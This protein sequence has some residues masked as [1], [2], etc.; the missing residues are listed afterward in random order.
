MHDVCKSA[1][2]E[3]KSFKYWVRYT[4]FSIGD[5]RLKMQ[6][7]DFKNFPTD[8]VPVKNKDKLTMI[9]RPVHVVHVVFAWTVTIFFLK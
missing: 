6:I 3:A 2:L 7:P 1:I 5:N 9:S 8:G 4:S